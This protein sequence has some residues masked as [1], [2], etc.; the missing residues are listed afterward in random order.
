L[1]TEQLEDRLVPSSATLAP[2]V[3]TNFQLLH[4]SG[5]AS[6][7]SSPGPVGFSPAQIRHAYGFDQVAFGS[8][9]GD[10]SGQTIAIIDAYDDPNIGNDLATFDQ[11]FGLAPPPSFT[12]VNQYG[13]T[14]FPGVD[15]IGRWE[16]E[17][18][19]DVE[20][21][22]AL[23]PKANIVLVEANSSAYSDM[24]AAVDYARQRAG[25]TVVSMSYYSAEFSGETAYDGHFTTP[26]GHAGV[27]FV[28][29][30]G[31]G[32]APPAY[33]AVSPNVLAAGG[34]TLTLNSSGGYA[35][36]VGWSSSG[37]GL[38]KYEVQ[39]SYQQ[40]TVTQSG[41]ARGSPDVAFD[42]DPH[43]GVAVCDSYNY[44]AAPWVRMGGTSFSAPA[45]AALVALADQGRA[46]SG[47]GSLDGASGT[48]PALY[49]LPATDFHDVTSGSNGN[50][51]GPGYDL[52]TGR[53]TP[54]ANL[55][56]S[57]LASSP[58]T[59]FSVAASAGSVTAG[60]TFSV[61][62]TALSFGNSTATAYTGTVHFTSSDAQGVLPA[63][64][65]F[66]AADQGVHTFRVTLKTAGAQSLAVTDTATAS[67][68]GTQS[69]ITVQPAA[70][71]R[72]VLSAPTQVNSNTA[73]SVTVTAYDAYGNV[74][75]GY[76]GT[77]HFTSTDR[78]AMLPGDYTFT[79]ADQGVHTFTGLRLRAKG[80]QTLTLTD[81]LIKSLGTSWTI[82]VV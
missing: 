52:V 20:W 70:A 74:A 79:A 78:R 47:L 1:Q 32:G 24:N 62:I 55:V 27:T 42:A 65:T 12:K 82:N 36:E 61:T 68:T 40:G 67:L 64:Y 54:L 2:A 50:T 60:T 26:A 57:H 31:D 37:G 53:G 10:G 30:S 43:S 11:A 16:T 41:T 76:T 46:Q 21:T 71:S 29:C 5:G 23:A 69:G 35:G 63:D 34:T 7:A 17:E 8:V 22:H 9:Q 77:V 3:H 14:A 56:A 58:A 33:P 19:L 28:A 4:P 25:V 13:G 59:H 48:L 73:F 49:R 39:P 15:S 51:A 44:G 6:P 66:T 72:L 75:T 80:K 45:W 38:S 81:T 18:A